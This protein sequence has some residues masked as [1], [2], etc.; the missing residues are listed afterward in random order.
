VV[1]A[2]RE[3][4]SQGPFV[5]AFLRR[6]KSSDIR[7]SVSLLRG[8]TFTSYAASATIYHVGNVSNDTKMRFWL[9]QHFWMLLPV[10]AALSLLVA[11]WTCDYL[12]ERARIRLGLTS[13]ANQPR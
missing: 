3:N 12:A 7:D 2:L 4:S 5:D 11:S 6:Y 1:V 8:S 10:G 9:T 13:L